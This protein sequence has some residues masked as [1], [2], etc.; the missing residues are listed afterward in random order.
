MKPRGPKLG[1]PHRMSA[2]S[3]C[4]VR[5]RRPDDRGTILPS[6]C[7]PGHGPQAMSAAFKPS[8]PLTYYRQI[9]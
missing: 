6:R 8:Q 5:S 9:T 1:N 3:P 2:I 7:S 4:M